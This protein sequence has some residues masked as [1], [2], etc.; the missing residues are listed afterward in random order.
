MAAPATSHSDIFMTVS[1]SRKT[2]IPRDKNGWNFVSVIFL[3]LMTK[4]LIGSNIR[5]LLCLTVKGSTASHSRK[6][7]AAEAG[8][9]C[10]HCIHS[11]EAGGSGQETQGL[12]PVAYFLHGDSTF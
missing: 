6:G 3:A 7:M 10:T 8:Y 12:S 5:G 4:F 9:N 1:W 11:Q 2:Q